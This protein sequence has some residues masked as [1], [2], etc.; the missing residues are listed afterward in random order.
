M[1]AAWGLLCRLRWMRRTDPDPPSRHGLRRG[2]FHVGLVCERSVREGL[3]CEE[4]LSECLMRARSASVSSKLG[5]LRG[6]FAM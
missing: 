1:P 5:I 3:V 6:G 4:C 2:I